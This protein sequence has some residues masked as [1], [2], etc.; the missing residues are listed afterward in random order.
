LRPPVIASPGGNVVFQAR[1]APVLLTSTATVSD[2]DTV[3]FKDARLTISITANANTFDR[4]AIKSQGTRAGQISL[5]KRN[6][7]YGGVTIGTFAGGTG[8]TPLT[9]TFNSSATAPAI[10]ALLRSIT[11][12]SATTKP[13]MIPRTVSFQLTDGT[14]GASAAV[15]KVVEVTAAAISG[16]KVK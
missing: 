7:R 10:Q 3:M 9:I 1:S 11:Y 12:G 13:T 14:G 4:L 6:V 5:S 15:T 8:A 16:K 2:A